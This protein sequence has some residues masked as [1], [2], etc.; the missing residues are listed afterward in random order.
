VMF[1]VTRNGIGWRRAVGLGMA[2]A[3]LITIALFP[4]FITTG[5][6][7]DSWRLIRPLLIGSLLVLLADL[8]ASQSISLRP[9]GEQALMVSMS[10]A[11]GVLLALWVGQISWTQ[12]ITNARNLGTGIKQARAFDT[13]PYKSLRG[14]YDALKRALPPGAVVAYT[15]DEGD[16]VDGAGSRSYNLDIIGAN[17]PDG[18]M[19]FFKGPAAKID[20]LR[21]QGITSLVTV[22]PGGS[23]CLYSAAAWVANTTGPKRVY[24]LWAP[25]FN[26]W[27]KDLP[28]MLRSGPTRSFGKL[29]LTQIGS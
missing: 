29:R 22:D 1:L 8:S 25:Y 27:F 20:Y 19:P 11:A 9:R 2:A 17:S 12:Q 10:A 16:L 23:A 18:H 5:S 24:Q 15:A 3:T 28:G 6:V 14:Q 4:V 26:D 7:D 21:S 13:D